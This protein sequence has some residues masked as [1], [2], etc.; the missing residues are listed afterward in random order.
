[1]RG[2]FATTGNAPAKTPTPTLNNQDYKP[3]C[4]CGEKHFYVECKYYNKHLRTKKWQGDKDIQNRVDVNMKNKPWIAEQIDKK[5]QATDDPKKDRTKPSGKKKTPEQDS[6]SD[7][8]ELTA[9][10][11][12]AF[13]CFQASEAP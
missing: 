4:I 10:S 1:L 5:L 12:A 8:G 6:D 13:T 9:Y 2:A 3:N 7:S 11:F